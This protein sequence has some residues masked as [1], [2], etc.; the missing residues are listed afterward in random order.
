MGKK[1]IS[2]HGKAVDGGIEGDPMKSN[3]KQLFIFLIPVI[4]LILFGIVSN[5][6]SLI[7]NID[8]AST[9]L[10]RSHLQTIGR[11][12]AFYLKER[13]LYP[14]DIKSDVRRLR[15][16]EP[17]DWYFL[18]DVTKVLV[19]SGKGS[20]EDMPRQYF[21]ARIWS[22]VKNIPDAPLQI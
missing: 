14:R 13:D 20:N 6:G 11:A 16:G 8:S 18:L 2:T 22:V 4:V 1:Y 7:I 10:A 21:D 15:T 17:N 9:A 5:L 3:K 19:D 12:I